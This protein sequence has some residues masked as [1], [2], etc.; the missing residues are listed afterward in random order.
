MLC[1]KGSGLG[2][3]AMDMGS[4]FGQMG[5]NMKDI[6]RRI[7]RMGRESSGTRMVTCLMDSGKMIRLMGT[8][9]IS[10]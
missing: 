9:F 4:R 7:R 2:R 3:G 6:G 10:M 1:I 8:A 5:R